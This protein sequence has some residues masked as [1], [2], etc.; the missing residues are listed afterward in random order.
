MFLTVIVGL[1]AKILSTGRRRAGHELAK[2]AQASSQ[3]QRAHQE[4]RLHGHR[5]LYQLSS[6]E[7]HVHDTRRIT[8]RTGNHYDQNIRSKFS[9][10]YTQNIRKKIF[11]PMVLIWV[12]F[13]FE[14]DIIKIQLCFHIEKMRELFNILEPENGTLRIGEY[15][16]LVSAGNDCL[17]IQTT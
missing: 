12:A 3:S 10:N 9:P 4:P 13:F 16:F 15:R 14:N 11:S 1:S 5:N 7:K 2:R 8:C 17:P 6:A